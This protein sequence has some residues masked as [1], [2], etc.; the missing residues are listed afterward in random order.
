MKQRNGFT[1]VELSIVLV[2]IGLIMAGI[3]MG[4]SMIENAEMRALTTEL[5]LYTTAYKEFVDKYQAIPGDMNNAENYWY[6]DTS[7]PGTPTNTT[8]KTPT[9]NG[10]GNGMIGDWTNTATATANS[11]REWFRAWQQL[12]N[13]GFIDGKFTGTSGGGSSTEALIGINAPASKTGKGGWTMLYMVS[14]GS[15]DTAFF[16]SAVASHMLMYGGQTSGSFTDS[17]I[18]SPTNMKSVDDKM[19]DGMPYTGKVRAKKST[20]ATCTVSGAAASDYLLTSTS[21]ACQLLFLMG[22]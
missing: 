18:L 16:N 11:E 5:N 19:D 6:S 21:Q 2:I 14:D 8:P 1:M 15:T 20:A 4:R 9:C 12:A 10:D 17:T 7:C 13:A 3:I 22:V